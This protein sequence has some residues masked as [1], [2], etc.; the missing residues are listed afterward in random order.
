MGWTHEFQHPWVARIDVWGILDSGSGD[1]V[2]EQQCEE[3]VKN[4][5]YFAWYPF[6]QVFSY[7]T[8]K[9]TAVVDAI[10]IYKLVSTCANPC[11]SLQPAHSPPTKHNS[12]QDDSLIE[13]L[14]RLI[15][16]SI[17]ASAIVLRLNLHLPREYV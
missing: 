10:M 15:H 5:P 1:H 7:L 12:I 3:P 14:E 13:W 6:L 16:L 17:R 4:M 8:T 11:V 9:F 2:K